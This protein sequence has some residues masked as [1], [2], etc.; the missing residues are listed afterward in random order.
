MLGYY[1]IHIRTQRHPTAHRQGN[2]TEAAGLYDA[3]LASPCPECDSGGVDA[4]WRAAVLRRAKAESLRRAGE[5]AAAIEELGSV[6]ALFPR[7]EAALYDMALSALDAGR[8]ATSIKLLEKLHKLD[9]HWPGLDD[10]LVHAHVAVRRAL[11]DQDAV[12]PQSLQ[13]ADDAL[14]RAGLDVLQPAWVGHYQVMPARDTLRRAW[15]I[16]SVLVGCFL[17]IIA[18]ICQ[19]NKKKSNALILVNVVSSM[20]H[21]YVVRMICMTCMFGLYDLYTIM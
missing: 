18:V 4:F 10:K 15:C 5:H 16:S 1:I 14:R 2:H 19:E 8:P 20:V 7:F 3:A 21:V 17:E 6:L 9:S 11:S 13:A 12:P